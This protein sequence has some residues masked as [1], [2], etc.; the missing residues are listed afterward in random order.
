MIRNLMNRAIL[1][2]LGVLPAAAGSFSS[3]FSNPN[4]TGFTLNG[5]TRPNGV[6]T[7]PTIADGVL[8]LA[9]P[10]GVAHLRDERLLA[11]LADGLAPILGAV[12]RIRIDTIAEAGDTLHA[13]DARA[14]DERQ[15]RAERDFNDNPTVRR[16]MQQFGAKL[17]PDS[18]RPADD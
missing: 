13:R 16:Y 2:A 9:L 8:T 15:A 17:V 10:A 4:Q 14:R 1:L 5:G 12:A 18:I 11:K 3:D 7:Y 6:D